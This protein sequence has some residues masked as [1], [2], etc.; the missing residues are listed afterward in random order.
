MGWKTCATQPEGW[1]GHPTPCMGTMATPKQ[2]PLHRNYQHNTMQHCPLPSHTTQP[3]GPPR[4]KQSSSDT[5]LPDLMFASSTAVIPGLPGGQKDLTK[6]SMEAG[7]RVHGLFWD[8]LHDFQVMWRDKGPSPKPPKMF[9]KAKGLGTPCHLNF[10][11]VFVRSWRVT[12][13]ASRVMEWSS[14]SCLRRAISSPHPRMTGTLGEAVHKQ[15]QGT[16]I[17]HPHPPLTLLPLP[18]CQ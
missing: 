18:C 4:P 14:T 16:D 5:S 3:R 7:P 12:R 1:T 8:Y 2:V 10:L 15:H 11:N 13:H 6:L 9:R 17:P